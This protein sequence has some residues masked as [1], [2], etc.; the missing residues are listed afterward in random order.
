MLYNKQ[1]QNL[2]FQTAVP[3]KP[4]TEKH[5]MR[6]MT[7]HGVF[8]VQSIEFRGVCSLSVHVVLTVCYRRSTSKRELRNREFSLQIL[9][10]TL[11]LPSKSIYTTPLA[12]P[13]RVYTR[14]H[15]HPILNSLERETS[16]AGEPAQEQVPRKSRC[17]L[18][19]SNPFSSSSLLQL[20]NP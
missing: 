18:P 2:L 19:F 20:T 3:G 9:S 8:G 10:V 1:V 11:P 16:W 14:T 12:Q 13:I 15:N 17:F 5:R 6:N 4:Q 7:W